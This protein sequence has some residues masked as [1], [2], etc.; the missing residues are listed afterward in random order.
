MVHRIQLTQTKHHAHV[1]NNM[2]EHIHMGAPNPFAKKKQPQENIMVRQK[3]SGDSKHLEFACHASQLSEA[4]WDLLVAIIALKVQACAVELSGKIRILETFLV[5]GNLIANDIHSIADVSDM[6]EEQLD[7]YKRSQLQ[8]TLEMTAI[9][10]MM[11]YHSDQLMMTLD[12]FYSRL[13]GFG[14]KSVKRSKMVDELRRLKNQHFRI[15]ITDKKDPANVKS[16]DFIF[17][18]LDSIMIDN[19]KILLSFNQEFNNAWTSNECM[20]AVFTRNMLLGDLIHVTW[21]DDTTADHLARLNLKTIL[22]FEEK[23]PQIWTSFWRAFTDRE[24]SFN[25]NG[26]VDGQASTNHLY[27]LLT[28]YLSFICANVLSNVYHVADNELLDDV[29]RMNDFFYEYMSI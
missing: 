6:D 23:D 8:E 15:E 16:T 10:N 11:G 18:P 17:K 25:F 22:N 27:P 28:F 29:R 24:C 13:V 14:I 21:R 3:L 5:Q 19:G 2:V 12:E 9:D 4:G 1:M 26:L 7:E 20:T